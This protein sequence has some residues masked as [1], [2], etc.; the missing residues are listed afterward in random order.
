MLS[1]ESQQQKH[2]RTW[3]QFSQKFWQW[4]VG[5]DDKAFQGLLTKDVKAA[6]Q[7]QGSEDVVPWAWT[8]EGAS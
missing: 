2:L 4:M 1:Q 3:F 7:L 8:A 6:L 5:S